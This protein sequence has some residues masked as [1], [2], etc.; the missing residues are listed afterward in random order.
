MLVQTFLEVHG[1]DHYQLG[2]S[3]EA[4]IQNFT[5]LKIVNADP[6]P[7]GNPNHASSVPTAL[8]FAEFYTKIAH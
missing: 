4:V 5:H 2:C 6:L 1:V 8:M 3:A 7:P